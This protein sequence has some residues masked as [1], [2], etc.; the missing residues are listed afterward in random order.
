MST[1]ILPKSIIEQIDKYRKHCLWRGSDAN[2]R[3]PPK[4]TW[5][6]VCIPK[7]EGGLEVLNLRT[8]NECLMLKHLDK[9]FNKASVPWVQLVWDKYY[10]NGKLP[11]IYNNFRGSFWWTDIL[12]L[13]ETCKGLAMAT[14]SNGSTCFFWLDLWDGTIMQNLFPELFSYSKNK[15]ISVQAMKT[16]PVTIDHFHLPL[17]NE[18]YEQF[19]QLNSIL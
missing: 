7:T 17:S 10:C 1:F 6:M 9:L 8:H 16:D 3:K 15:L 2:K 5:P 4:A 13:L 19:E 18:A 12:K 14:V 11:R